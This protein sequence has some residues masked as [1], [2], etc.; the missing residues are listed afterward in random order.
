[1]LRLVPRVRLNQTP[2]VL[3]LDAGPVLTNVRITP[4]M[5]QSWLKYLAPLVAEATQAEGTFSLMLEETAVPLVQPSAAQVRGIVAVDE[6]RIG[7]GSLAMQLLELA[8]R[9]RA[10]VQGRL[11]SQALRPADTWVTLPAQQT[12]FQFVD[13]RVHHDRC[14]FQIGDTLVRTRGSVGVDQTLALVAELPIPDAWL[15]RDARLAVLR[16]TT[17]QIPVSGTFDRPQLDAQALEQLSTQVLRQTANRMLEEGVQR[18][19]Q[20]LLGPR[21]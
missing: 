18:G 19:L 10:L 4:G 14:E 7:P 3:T 5:C 1:M 12:R 16:G 13:G 9:I 20:Q 21:R 8:E 17:L 2:S 15:A 11:P 6:A